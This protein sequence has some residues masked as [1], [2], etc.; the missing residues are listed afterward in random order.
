MA[1]EVSELEG[2]RDELIR[3]RA[4]GVRVTAYEGKRLE[5]GSDAEMAAA[6]A[7]L[8]RRISR[9][10]RTPIRTVRAISSKGV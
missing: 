10:S 9:A 3:A 1:I 5:Y 4:R 7:D 2:L 8:D 6:I